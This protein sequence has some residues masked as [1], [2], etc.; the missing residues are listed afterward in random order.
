[1]CIIARLFILLTDKETWLSKHCDSYLHSTLPREAVRGTM[2]GHD[3]A[4]G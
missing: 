1:M 4:R 2:E 3:E